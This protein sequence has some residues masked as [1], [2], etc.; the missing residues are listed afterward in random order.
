LVLNVNGTEFI[1]NPAI[2]IPSDATN[3]S[4]TPTGLVAARIG[5]TSDL[6]AVGQLQLAKFDK[7]DKLR[8]ISPAIYTDTTESGFALQCNP[9]SQGVGT[10]IQ[11]ALAKRY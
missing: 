3:V 4:I 11:G 9:G 2:Q 5:N 6:S 1:V 10:V 7:P 8:Q